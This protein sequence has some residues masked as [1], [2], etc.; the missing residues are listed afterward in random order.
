MEAPSCSAVSFAPTSG[1]PG[2]EVFATLPVTA[3]FV[4]TN[5][6]R[7]EVLVNNPVNGTS[8]IFNTVGTFPISVTMSNALS[9][10]VSVTC[11][12]L[13][14]ISNAPINGV[15]SATM[16]NQIYYTGN[17]PNTGDLCTAG[18]VTG[19][20]QTMTGWSWSCEGVN[21]GTTDTACTLAI[22]YC[23]DGVL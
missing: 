14:T 23:G 9:G 11:T 2:L 8:H 1:I 19:L 20:T 12:G 18:I 10:A 4:Y 13:V 16:N 21:G 15:C 6:D 22:S 7:S 5:L 3:G 17:L